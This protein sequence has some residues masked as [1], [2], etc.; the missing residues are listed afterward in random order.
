[1]PA[2]PIHWVLAGLM[3]ASGGAAFAMAERMPVEVLMGMGVVGWMA[4]AGAWATVAKEGATA[5]LRGSAFVCAGWMGLGVVSEFWRMWVTFLPPDPWRVGFV[6]LKFAVSGNGEMYDVMLGLAPWVAGTMTVAAVVGVVGSGWTLVRRAAGRGTWGWTSVWGAAQGGG[7]VLRRLGIAA[8]MVFG[9]G[10]WWMADRLPVG[11]LLAAAFVGWAM[12]LGTYF[13]VPEERGTGLLRAAAYAGAGC[14]GVGVV[15]QF[16]TM[17]AAL[18]PVGPWRA[19]LAFPGAVAAVQENL[20]GMARL[21]PWIAGTMTFF[22]GYFALSAVAGS[23]FGRGGGDGGR[24]HSESELFGASRLMGRRMLRKMSRGGGIILGSTAK[25]GGGELVAYPLE[26]AALTVAP[27]RSGKTALIAGNLLAPDGKGY[28]KGSTVIIDPRGELFFVAAARRKALGRNVVLVDPFGLVKELAQEPRFKEV[29]RVPTVESVTFNPLDFIREGDEGVG[30][31]RALLEGLLTAPA[32][33]GADNARHFYESA[34]ALMSGVVAYVH[35]LGRQEDEGSLRF[36][37]VRRFLMADKEVEKIMREDIEGEPSLGW[38]LPLDAIGRMDKVGQAEGGSNYSTIAN[39]VDWLQIPEL[40]RS[41]GESTFDPMVLTRGNTDLFVVVPESRLEVSKP[42]LRL[43]V[44]VAN[45]VA[46]RKLDHAGI[47]IVIDEAPRLGY[48]K[49][50]VDSFYMAAGKGIRYQI[51]A[52]T[53]SA[54]DA[55]FQR[56]NMDIITDLAEV[57]Q[58]LEFPR[59]NPEFADRVSKMIGN[60]TFVNTSRSEQGTVSGEDV[61]RRQ[62]SV[63]SGT[64]QSLVKERLIPPE[65][66]MMLDVD[67]Q[68]VLTNSKVVGRDAMKLFLVRYWERADMK[69][70]AAPNPYVLRKEAE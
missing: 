17:W 51:Y 42:W 26:G 58:I 56:E 66:L 52:Q 19:A 48:L 6:S 38:G 41:T 24:K 47:T 3:M 14:V 27:P 63:Q 64:N 49:P 7:A 35:W 70:L 67:Q 37:A 39:Q 50:V 61:L 46:E 68:I 53:K 15:E 36:G 23:M 30:D 25:G 29:V 8:P 4:V 31:V 60:A 33:Q 2:R 69:D 32:R 28:V 13:V 21:T 57:F 59:A 18:L 43:W 22:A 1:M 54:M 20:G 65:D 40:E 5:L 34:K 16:W 10:I 11:M 12:V 44:V 9:G 45:A 55:V 62:Q